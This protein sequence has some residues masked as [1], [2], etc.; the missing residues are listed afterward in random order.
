MDGAQLDPPA[1][2]SERPAT[3]RSALKGL[4]GAALA[5]LAALRLPRRT[6]TLAAQ[7]ATPE[8]SPVVEG[9]HPAFLFVQLAESGT[10]SPKPGEDGIYLLTLAGAGS[11]TLYFSD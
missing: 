4:A 8:A 9:Q 3:R 1:Q 11:Q 7:D 6:S 2:A 10:W 5:G